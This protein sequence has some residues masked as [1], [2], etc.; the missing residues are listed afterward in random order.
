MCFSKALNINIDNGRVKIDDNSGLG[1]S[2]GYGT[3]G[4]PLIGKGV[5]EWFN[6][7]IE[8]SGIDGDDIGAKIYIDGKYFATSNEKAWAGKSYANISSLKISTSVGSAGTFAF[9]DIVF[10]NG[11]LTDTNR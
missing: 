8:I 6:L 10:G 5:G 9:D 1:E 11:I 2:Y 4:N 3:M 7:K